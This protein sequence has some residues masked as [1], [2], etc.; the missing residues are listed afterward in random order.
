MFKERKRSQLKKLKI[1]KEWEGS[2]R[3]REDCFKF[4]VWV[5]VWESVFKFL[6][7]VW[8]TSKFGSQSN[9]RA[10][11]AR[12]LERMVSLIQILD[13][14]IFSPN[15]RGRTCSGGRY[16]QIL[17]CSSEIFPLSL[18][19]WNR[20]NLL[21]E[22]GKWRFPMTEGFKLLW[23]LKGSLLL[24]RIYLWMV[25]ADY[26]VA[27]ICAIMWFPVAVLSNPTVIKSRES[28]TP[29]RFRFCHTMIK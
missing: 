12:S 19:L 22:L 15:R 14:F 7:R 1:V 3:I 28:W 13:S 16:R 17:W 25:T 24:L 20:S 29:L 26:I 9:H 8:C 4:K 18:F 21:M 2:F 5:E 6:T 11:F 27:P 10:D 23:I